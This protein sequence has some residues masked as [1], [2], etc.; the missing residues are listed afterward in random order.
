[1]ARV[2][3]L[4]LIPL[5]V[6]LVIGVLVVSTLRKGRLGINLR[7]VR[8]SSCDTPMSARRR[9]MF[10]SQLL[11]GGW[12]CPHCGTNM[13]KWGRNVSETSS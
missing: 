12:T 8:C 7:P 10:K 5:V 3:W 4:Y 2:I 1:M 9:P 6:F 11:L 13:D